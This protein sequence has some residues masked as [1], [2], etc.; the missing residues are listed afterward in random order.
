MSPSVRY[1]YLFPACDWK[2]E[3]R[4]SE[5]CK[6]RADKKFL[7]SQEETLKIRY[8]CLEQCTPK[9]IFI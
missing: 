4:R 1:G 6:E 8:I 7:I 5:V 9:M 3:R 2:T